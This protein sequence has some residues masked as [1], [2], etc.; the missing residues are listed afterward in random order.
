[1]NILAFDT[2]GAACSAAVLRRGEVVAHRFVAMERGHAEALLP[3]IRDVMAEAGL[4]WSGL[5]RI[6]VTTGPGAF[7]GIRIGLAAARGLALASSLP[8][9]GVSTFEAVASACGIEGAGPLLVALE[10]RREAV[11]VQLF[12]PDGESPPAS[13]MPEELAGFVPPGP[14]RL[15]GDGAERAAASLRFGGRN[16]FIM[17]GAAPP[18][19]AEV[20]RVALR[21]GLPEPGGPRPLYLRAPDVSFPAAI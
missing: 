18:D 10:S 12:R 4:D 8:L 21:A 16:D 3:M 20:G 5:S 14:F 1:M 19:A 2:S 7:T 9:Y 6:A 15:C 11:F 17:A 13:V